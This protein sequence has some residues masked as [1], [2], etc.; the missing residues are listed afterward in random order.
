[1]VEDGEV[2][3]FKNSDGKSEQKRSIPTKGSFRWASKV[4]SKPE[5]YLDYLYVKNGGLTFKINE[6]SNFFGDAF[7]IIPPFYIDEV[8]KNKMND[9]NDIQVMMDYSTFIHQGESPESVKKCRN[10]TPLYAD[11]TLKHG[12]LGNESD[13]GI[14]CL[15]E[16]NKGTAILLDNNIDRTRLA[17]QLEEGEIDDYLKIYTNYV[18]IN[19]GNGDFH[20][21]LYFNI[22]NMFNSPFEYISSVTKQPNV[23]IL[24]DSFLYLPGDKYTNGMIDEEKVNEIKKGGILTIYGQV[25]IYQDDKLADVNTMK[26]FQYMIYNISDDKPKFMISKIY[27]ITK[28]QLVNS[29]INKVKLE[30]SDVLHTI[31]P[32]KFVGTEEDMGNREIEL[33]EL[34]SKLE[35][36]KSEK[37]ILQASM[38]K[39]VKELEELNK[40]IE[41]TRKEWEY[42]TD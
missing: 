32:D 3:T 36:K 42:E 30:F 5:K 22:Q 18:K 40:Q 33:S 7:S 23:L 41:N 25:K 4:K 16:D 29:M 9:L 24:R 37:S 26:L 27:D 11:A 35:S 15:E 6:E 10:F 34:E 20:Y 31:A 21:D 2:I 12:I 8:L 28:S 19:D 39:Q 38:K 14:I 17:L 1:M 13:G